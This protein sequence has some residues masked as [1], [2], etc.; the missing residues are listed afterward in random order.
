MDSF[1]KFIG[2]DQPA[3][4]ILQLQ[5]RLERDLADWF[6]GDV[7]VSYEPDHSK[8][9]FP[10]VST[11]VGTLTD[12]AGLHGLLNLIRDLGITIFY[13]DCLDARAGSQKPGAED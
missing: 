1:T 11:V 12:Q 13:V 4:Y 5:G 10:G 8:S 7:T 3:K 2:V 9:G 6:Q